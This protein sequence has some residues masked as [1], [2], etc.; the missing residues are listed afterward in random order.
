MRRESDY[1]MSSLINRV[2]H[3][4][5]L[6]NFLGIIEEIIQAHGNTGVPFGIGVSIANRGDGAEWR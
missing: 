2:I 6:N 3:S 4:L 5:F 1:D